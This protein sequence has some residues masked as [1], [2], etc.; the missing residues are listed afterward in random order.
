MAKYNRQT[1][2]RQKHPY[3]C[4]NPATFMG[5]NQWYKHMFEKLGWMIL[6]KSYG[7]MDDKIISYT[8][9]LYRLKDKIKCKIDA[10][11]DLDKRDDLVIMLRNVNILIR[12][13]QKDLI[14]V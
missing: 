6:A 13:A 11:T 4:S 9:S 14:D 1:R 2:K 3:V 5:L 10:M 7:D 12:H 8:H